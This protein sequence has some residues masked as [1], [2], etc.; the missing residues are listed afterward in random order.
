MKEFT[1]VVINNNQNINIYRQDTF[2]ETI[3]KVKE[4]RDSYENFDDA[5]T[6]W[7]LYKGNEIMASKD[8][9]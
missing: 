3:E 7:I 5:D 6:K 8:I 1:L 4:L 9:E 2:D